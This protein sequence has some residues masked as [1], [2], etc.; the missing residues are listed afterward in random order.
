MMVW[1]SS[2]YGP[3]TIKSS[4]SDV[5][6]VRRKRGTT[7]NVLQ[8]ICINVCVCVYVYNRI[9]VQTAGGPPRDVHIGQA[10]WQ[11]FVKF[12]VIIGS[13][14][15]LILH[16]SNL[17][18]GVCVGSPCNFQLDKCTG[19]RNKKK[20]KKTRKYTSEKTVSLSPKD[21]SR[22]TVWWKKNNNK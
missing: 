7:R 9:G 17:M 19:V 2:S 13:L 14:N 4:S 6:R 12:T 10:G 11:L 20:K 5:E 21:F 3:A 18:C 16:V 22:R 8:W 1:L 15:V